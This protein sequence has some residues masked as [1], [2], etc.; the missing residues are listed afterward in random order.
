VRQQTIAETVS[1]TGI[2]LT[3]GL[4]VQLTLM[5]APPDSGVVFVRTDRGEPTEV[6]AHPAN[7]SSTRPTLAL[8]AGPARVRGIGHLCAALF[9]LG[10]DNL[11]VAVSGPELPVMDGSAAPFVF[12]LRSAGIVAQPTSRPLLRIRRPIEVR[13]GARFARIEPGRGFRIV[14]A[15]EFEHRAIGRQEYRIDAFD[16]NHFE[17]EISAARNFGFQHELRPLGSTG[18]MRGGSLDNTVVLDAAGVVNRDGLRWPDEFVRHKVLDLLACL[19]LLGVGIQGRIHV[20]RGG[21]SLHREL[22]AAIAAAPDAWRIAARESGARREFG[23]A[24]APA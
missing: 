3:S 16:P 7:L 11:R 23:L 15:V 1:C 19:G 13:D 4:P 14:Y 8:G 20:E 17:R 10:I 12:L 9:G 21:R 18:R 5:P 6:H 24:P 2:A 22:V